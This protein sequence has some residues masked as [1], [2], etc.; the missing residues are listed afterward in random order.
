MQ[1]SHIASHRS[2]LLTTALFWAACC[3]I[4][5]GAESPSTRPQS[6]SP[7]LN[8]DAFI[9]EH[10]R[11]GDGMLARDEVPDWI[12]RAFDRIDVDRDGKLSKR[13]LAAVSDRL[14]R[15]ASPATQP[16]GAA[17]ATQPARSTPKASANNRTPR[18]GAI[19]TRPALAERFPERLK[20]GDPAPDFTL[21]DPAGKREVTLSELLKQKKPVVLVF[22]SYTCPPF[23]GHSPEVERLYQSFKE[24][25]EFLLVYIRE[26]HP[27]SVL[28]TRKDAGPEANQRI[29]QT[30]DVKTRGEHAEICRTMLGF[31]FPAVV[32]REENKVSSA[33]AGWPI[34][35]V[36]VTPDG[37]VAYPGGP[38]PSGFKPDEVRDWL[39]AN[40][41][42]Q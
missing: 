12:T 40:T 8:L 42:K 10:D 33:Y 21:P 2:A 15:R 23:R 17:P 4:A 34:R 11:N 26:A 9:A 39:E 3:P 22:C 1:R 28:P 16:A 13:E 19:N 6:T 41:K 7:S 37:K 25:A 31:T 32:D 38:G 18:P 36:I 27:G 20:A 35:L 30:S 14:A 29:D 5:R 24:R